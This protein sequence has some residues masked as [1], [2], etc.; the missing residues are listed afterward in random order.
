[1]IKI[2]IFFSYFFILRIN[3]FVG[4]KIGKKVKVVKVVLEVHGVKGVK[5][6]HGEKLKTGDCTPFTSCTTCTSCAP[7]FL[8]VVVCRFVRIKQSGESKLEG[9][10]VALDQLCRNIEIRRITALTRAQRTGRHVEE[11]HTRQTKS[12]CGDGADDPGHRV[13]VRTEETAAF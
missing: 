7:F 6:A 2:P 4:A 10:G 12:V 1:M 13:N 8:K 5:L 9:R 3:I 11:V